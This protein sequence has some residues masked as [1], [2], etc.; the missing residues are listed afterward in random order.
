LSDAGDIANPVITGLVLVIPIRK[1]LRFKPSG[2]PAQ[3]RP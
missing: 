1:A 3:G 2:W